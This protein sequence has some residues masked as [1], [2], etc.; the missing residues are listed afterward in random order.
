MTTR[1]IVLTIAVASAIVASDAPTHTSTVLWATSP[2]VQAEMP[3]WTR[4]G[5]PGAGHKTLE[6]LVG[7]WRVHK[8]IFGTLGRRADAPPLISDDITTRREWVAAGRYIEDTTEGTIDGAPYWRRGW[9]GY[10][11]E[12]RRYEWVTI[13]ALNTTMM[14]YVGRRGSGPS[15]TFSMS[16]TFTDQGVVGPETVGK[17]VGQRTTVR[18][19]S[20]DRHIIELYFTPPGKPEQLADRSLYTRVVR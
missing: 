18:I 13:D 4:R 20:S 17:A 14:R 6:P 7:T 1:A 15:R 16:G 10:S 12:D 19:D 8:E 3:D 5:L 11:N 9:L 2:S